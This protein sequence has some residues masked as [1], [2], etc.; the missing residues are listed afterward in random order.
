MELDFIRD[1]TGMIL[2][3]MPEGTGIVFEHIPDGERI[4]A[5]I[6]YVF[7]VGYASTVKGKNCQ[8]RTIEHLMA[9]CHMYGITNLLVKVS[10]EVP[11]FDGSALEMCN[12]I[13]KAGVIEKEAGVGPSK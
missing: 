3:P 5:H 9:T 8:V 4:P 2:L 6:D 13:E 11:I 7:S 10:E 1:K 12:N